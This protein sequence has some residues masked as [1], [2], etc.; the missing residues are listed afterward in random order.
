M[1]F[2][3]VKLIKMIIIMLKRSMSERKL[4]NSDQRT[5]TDMYLP[6]ICNLPS[7]FFA[8]SSFNFSLFFSGLHPPSTLL[9]ALKR[10]VQVLITPVTAI[11]SYHYVY[12][13]L[14]SSNEVDR[15]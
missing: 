10:S 3:Q 14:D 4:G 13:N 9:T 15:D 12:K 6:H 8:T 11:F 2:L 1:N 7:N 5:N